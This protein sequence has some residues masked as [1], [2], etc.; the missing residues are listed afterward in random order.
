VIL[1]LHYK[2][3]QVQLFLSHFTQQQDSGY[4]FISE[5]QKT[6]AFYRLQVRRKTHSELVCKQL[7]SKENSLSI[8]LIS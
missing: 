1:N 8:G 7:K 4:T 2:Q 5:L 6:K 3:R